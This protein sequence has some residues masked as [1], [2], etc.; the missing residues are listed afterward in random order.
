MAVRSEKKIERELREVQRQIR[1]YDPEK[2]SY[3]SGT[4]GRL[5]ARELNLKRELGRSLL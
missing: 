4:I 5:A 1:Q 2:R 3:E